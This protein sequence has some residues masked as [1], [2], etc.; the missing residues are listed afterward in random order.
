MKIKYTHIAEPN[1]VK[2]LDTVLTLKNN[3][4]ITATQAEHDKFELRKFKEDKE[5]GLIMSYEVIEE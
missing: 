2:T 5:K 1:K 4:F 3:P